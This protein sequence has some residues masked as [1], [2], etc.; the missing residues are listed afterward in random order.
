MT[1]GAAT[2]ASDDVDD[3]YEQLRHHGYSGENGYG[4]LLL[5]NE[6]QAKVIRSFRVATG[7]SWD[8]I[9]ATGQPGLFLPSDQQLFG[10]GQAASTYAG[11]NVQGTY[12]YFTVVVDDM[13]PAG[14]VTAIATGGPENLGNPVGFRQHAN[15]SLQ[16]LRLVKGPNPD[17]P[18]IDSFYNRGFGTGIRQR[19]GAAVLQVTTSTTYTAPTF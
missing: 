3:L 6:T 8:F 10:A 4:H 11:L 7:A 13:F 5:V 1:T 16:G 14:W 9:P 17:Y 18:L 2:L 15:T 19:G 12:G